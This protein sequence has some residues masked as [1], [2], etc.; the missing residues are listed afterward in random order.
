MKNNLL[1]KAIT[2]CLT[3][4]VW[5]SVI[6]QSYRGKVADEQNQPIKS[7]TIILL[8]DAKNP[9]SFAKTSTK[10]EF[11]IASPTTKNPIFMLVSC[12]N[13]AKDTIL[14]KNF[15]SNQTIVLKEQTIVINNVDV[16]SE[17]IK[18]SSDTL[19]YLVSS[20]KHKQDRSIAD[21]I[22]KM[23]GIE[24]TEDGTIE[25]HGVKINR[26]YIEGMDFMGGKYS[27]VSEN[28]SANK[29]K[30]VQVLE[31]HQPIKMLQNK[32]FSNQAA[33]NLILA[34]SVKNVWQGFVDISQGIS[35][36][37]DCKWLSDLSLTEMLFAKN[38]QSISIYKYNNDGIDIGKE[39]NPL[40]IFEKGAPTERNL[41][42]LNT[43]TLSLDKKRTLFNNT[44][45][46]ATN[47]L[48]KPTKDVDIRFQLDGKISKE[49]YQQITSISYLD[50]SDS[51]TIIDDA[52]LGNYYSEYSAELLYNKNSDNMYLHN[53]LKGYIDFNKNEGHTLWNKKEIPVSTR[54][55]K[56]YVCDYMN[57]VKEI[58]SNKSMSFSGYLSYNHLPCSLLL[59][60]NTSQYF[61]LTSFYAGAS[62]DFRHKIGKANLTY[63]LSYDGIIKK[64]YVK[65]S[66]AN[67]TEK[68][69][70]NR[71]QSG[72]SLSHNGTILRQ[73]TDVMVNILHKRLGYISNT[74]IY[75]KPN[76][77]LT[78]TPSTNWNFSLGYSYDM[79]TLNSWQTSLLPLFTDYHT[80][81][82]GN[83][84]INGEYTHT[85]SSNL[86]Y[87][88]TKHG[89]FAN[90]A[91]TWNLF[92]N[93]YIY[94]NEVHNGIYFNNITVLQANIYDFSLH[95]QVSKSCRWSKL[96]MRLSFYLNY[97]D[98]KILM[99]NEIAPCTT[100]NTELDI[101]IS[102]QP[103]DWLSIKEKSSWSQS[104]NDICSKVKSNKEKV[105][106]FFH[107]I[108]VYLM[109]GKWVIHWK[110][111][112]YHTSGKTMY[113]NFFSDISCSYRTKTYE[114]GITISNIRGSSSYEQKIIT[115]NQ[116]IYTKTRL[117]PREL[118]CRFCYNL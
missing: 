108:N 62:T 98:N 15:R 56:R 28:L 45:I 48:F 12:I 80:L 14:V 59:T 92:R 61:N 10:G 26:F 35:L 49:D 74:F 95:A 72:I 64:N 11:V 71:W 66:Y 85:I 9:I 19:N 100:N 70:E 101:D 55:R 83:G 43:N 5:N 93:Q 38:L 104:I 23:P 112:L 37:N 46:F 94:Q 8:D 36:Q 27:Q 86:T 47:W 60:D 81:R 90:F 51:T 2:L 16:V 76:L 1:H 63:L 18:Q 4:A 32:I 105:N 115:N 111:E 96:F 106:L 103:T 52:Q 114:I 58:G 117:R 39:I 30:K 25:Y 6:A 31:N 77:V 50:V 79:K 99:L 29:V 40:K 84:K 65:N 57:I 7:A 82:K 21:V 41:F 3:L 34:D 24:V 75:V 118:I 53:S 13:Y 33:L 67:E 73:R 91:T 97:L 44:H 109:P 68:Y 78:F 42:T 116:Q 20:F 113:R 88:K 69:F 102:L 54:P 107:E 110:N 17:R 22:K 89:F 87:K